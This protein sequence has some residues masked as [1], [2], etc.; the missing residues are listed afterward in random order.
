MKGATLVI[1]AF[2]AFLAG[3]NAVNAVVLWAQFGPESSIQ[4]YLISNLIGDLSVATYL[5]IS[6][7]ATFVFL[8]MTVSNMI[9][10]LPDPNLLENVREK[11]DS[12][13]NNQEALE[14]MKTRLMIID[15]GLGDVR[16]G[17]LEGFNQQGADMKKI[18]K[19]MFEKFD[20]KLADFKEEMTRQ[21][22]KMSDNVRKV[23]RTNKKNTTAFTKQNKQI[24]NFKSNLEKL[25]EEL[26]PPEPKL[27]SRSEI[28][29][30]KGIGTRLANEMKGIGITSVGELILADPQIIVD[31]TSASARK[32]EKLQTRAQLLMVP[33]IKEKDI[34][35]LENL[36]ITTRRSL[37]E[38]DPIE[39][40]RKM[41]GI[42]KAYVEKGKVSEEE[43]PTIEEIDSWISNARS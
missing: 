17:F 15:A 27:T 31:K 29:K 37:A 36:D 34:A 10:N 26:T 21:L 5:W 9:S 1:L 8:G 32:V 39:L 41:N 23:E 13:Q 22:K 19:E 40:G 11:I 35:L 16:K 14:K 4:P 24:A 7:L 42:L 20:K 2:F 3:L 43:K 6:I 18:R 25:E 28:K 30:V 12:L 33:G 38:Q